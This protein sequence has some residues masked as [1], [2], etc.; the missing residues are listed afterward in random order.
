MSG[1][2]PVG[3]NYNFQ[4]LASTPPPSQSGWSKFG[5]I[6]GSAASALPMVGS[7]MNSMGVDTSFNR[8]YEMIMMQQQI[9][10]QS[11]IF[12]TMS[13]VSKSKHEAAMTA[14]RNMK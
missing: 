8:Q 6:L 11:Q 10:T 5:Q 14:I 13:N 2:N 3:Q 12:N 1:I 9:Q 7:A 4:Q